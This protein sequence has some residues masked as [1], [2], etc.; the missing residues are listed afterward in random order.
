MLTFIPIKPALEDNPEFVKN[1]D[2]RESLYMTIDYYKTIGF[3]PPWICYYV[4]VDG[5]LVGCAGFKG[6]PLNNRIEIAYGTFPDFRVQGIGT[7]ICKQLVS[8]ALLTDPSI[9]ITA[10]TLP[11]A[12]YS[13]K[14]LGKNGFKLLGDV[15]DK[16]D[17]NV[18]EWEYEKQIV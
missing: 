14:T 9:I 8:L 13:T 17:G 7:E 18:W 2:C 16:E 11:E 10:R 15:W 5:K 4:Q 6:R 3:Y 12:N 1:P